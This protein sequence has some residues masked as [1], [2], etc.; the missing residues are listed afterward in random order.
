MSA[1]L[2]VGQ[3]VKW[4]EY[5]IRGK[6][7]YW[8]RQGSSTAKSAARQYLDEAMA[9]RGIVLESKEN[10]YVV[11]FDGESGTHSCLSYLVEAAND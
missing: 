11:K 5:V 3:R 7:D 6:R 4:S 8:L 2:Q 9:A 1:N 10:G